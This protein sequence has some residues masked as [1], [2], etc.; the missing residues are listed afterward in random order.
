MTRAQKAR[1][2]F[3]GGL[4]C[5]QS[6]VMAFSDVLDVPETTLKAALLPLGGGMGRLRETCG[7]VSGAAVTLGL[8][9]AGMGK[10]E[11]YALVQ[12]LARRFTAKNGAINCGKLLSGA[13]LA[14]DT[15]PTPEARTSEY[16]HKRP[17]PELVYDAAQI[18]EEICRERGRL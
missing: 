7:A 6:V 9:F 14:V 12:E 11:M 2:N 4:N 1:E 16:Y 10:A 3:L 13:G 17:C 8:L 5:S 15:A 18:V